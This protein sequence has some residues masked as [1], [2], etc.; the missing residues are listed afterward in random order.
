[1]SDDTSLFNRHTLRWCRILHKVRKNQFYGVTTYVEISTQPNHNLIYVNIFP[2]YYEK[3]LF[4][5]LL[6]LS[7]ARLLLMIQGNSK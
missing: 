4:L 3:R 6:K 2:I 1:M 5:S 7:Y